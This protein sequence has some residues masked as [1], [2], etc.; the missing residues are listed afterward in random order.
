MIWA[1]GHTAPLVGSYFSN[2]R[3][4]SDLR[5]GECRVLTTGPPGNSLKCYS[6]VSQPL[7]NEMLSLKAILKVDS[8]LELAMQF[9]SPV[10]LYLP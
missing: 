4:N 5:Q 9:T 7:K 1:W 8:G 6:L 10:K 2:Q 3:L